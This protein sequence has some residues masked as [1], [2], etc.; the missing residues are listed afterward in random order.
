ML[1]RVSI[2]ENFV[3]EMFGKPWRR[4][5]SLEDNVYNALTMHKT[6]QYVVYSEI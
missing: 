2:G 6:L 5:P 4:S 3:R 1:L